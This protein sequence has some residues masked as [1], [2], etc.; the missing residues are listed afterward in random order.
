MFLGFITFLALGCSDFTPNF[1]IACKKILEAAYHQT[2]GKT[3]DHKFN[4]YLKEETNNHV[5][6][7]NEVYVVSAAGIKYSVT[8][9]AEFHIPA[10]SLGLKSISFE[11]NSKRN[12]HS[13]NFNWS[14]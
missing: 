10:K 3:T 13:I 8:K 14:F 1:N 5:D 2:G 6:L 12:V 7:N 9:K 4:K 11:T